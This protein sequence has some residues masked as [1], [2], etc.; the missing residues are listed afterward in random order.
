MKELPPYSRHTT[1]GPHDWDTIEFPH[2][3][4]FVYLTTTKTTIR[5]VGHFFQF[6]FVFS[7]HTVI[8]CILSVLEPLSTVTGIRLS[9][10][11]FSSIPPDPIESGRPTSTS[12]F[13]NPLSSTKRYLRKLLRS[14]CVKK[15]SLEN[16][17]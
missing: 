3:L 6:R 2:N 9:F 4:T 13:T 14:P 10:L 11:L 12:F 7:S 5:F 8:K 1:E 17:E 15:C 16:F